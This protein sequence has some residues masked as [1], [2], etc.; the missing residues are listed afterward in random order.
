LNGD[1]E[2]HFENYSRNTWKFGNVFLEKDR[3]DQVGRACEK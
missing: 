1:E 2:G 3:E